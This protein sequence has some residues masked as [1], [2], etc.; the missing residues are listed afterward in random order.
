MPDI[1]IN[2]ELARPDGGKVSAGAIATCNSPRPVTNTMQIV[3]ALVIYIT[4]TALDNGKQPIPKLDKFPRMKVIK[5]CDE[6]EWTALND[7]PNAGALMATFMQE[8][9]DAEIGDGFTEIVV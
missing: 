8:A 1:K 2:K 4:Q 6:A 5:Q 9:I 7:D 3:F